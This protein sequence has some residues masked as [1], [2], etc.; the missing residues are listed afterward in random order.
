MAILGLTYKV[1]GRSRAILPKYRHS[2]HIRQNWN[3]DWEYIPY[4]T[5]LSAT[6]AILP[7]RSRAEFVYRFGDMKREDTESFFTWQSLAQRIAGGVYDAYIAIRAWAQDEPAYTLWTGIVPAQSFD[8]FATQT[9]LSPQLAGMSGDQRLVAYG[10]DHVVE[11]RSVPG[12]WVYG[13]GTGDH[14]D[15]APQ[16]NERLVRGATQIGNRSEFKIDYTPPAGSPGEVSFGFGNDVDSD[17]NPFAWSVRDVIEYLLF[18]SGQRP[19]VD[20]AASTEPNFVIGGPTT[21]LGKS[22]HDVIGYLDGLQAITRQEGRNVWSMLKE[23]LPRTRGIGATFVPKSDSVPTIGSG[24]TFF[25]NPDHL[26]PEGDMELQLFSL[27]D[28]PGVVGDFEFPQNP[29]SEVI[30]LDK[31]RDVEKAIISIDSLKT[32]DKVIVQ[33]SRTV[34]AFSCRTTPGEELAAEI[35]PAWSPADETAYEQ[36]RDI[37][38]GKTADEQR[39]DTRWERVFQTFR[40]PDDFDW[41]NG[42]FQLNPTYDADGEVQLSR[43]GAFLNPPDLLSWLPIQSDGETTAE[44]KE[45]RLLAPIVIVEKFD[46]EGD[47]TG[48]WQQVETPEDAGEPSGAS[49]T[50]E[51]RDG[52]MKISYQD[53]PHVLARNHFTP[54]TDPKFEPVFDYNNMIVTIAVRTDTRPTVEVLTGAPGGK[55]LRV[56]TI[57]I[58][59]VEV[60]VVAPGTVDGIRPH[61]QPRFFPG[62]RVVRD[63]TARLRSVAALAKAVYSKRRASVRVTR[64]GL[65]DIHPLGRMIAGVTVGQQ[66]TPVNAVVMQR[67]WD[68]VAE[69]TTVQTGILNLDVRGVR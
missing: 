5:A 16:F 49:V 8:I 24:P 58:P 20:H 30:V 22:T 41:T 66:S 44:S 21:A 51:D 47:P 7:G 39:T 35:E 61:G 26:L 2:V 46:D 65:L 53:V 4:L 68:F 38:D 52:L 62:G 57:P 11:R 10:W 56:L 37:V 23:L 48:V 9:V 12:A 19:L 27:T 1:P 29:T 40:F 50:I 15:W 69:T 3:D 14:I 36:L 33:G 59:E 32:Y 55:E 28:I 64:K 6:Q 63:D 67:T 17:G 42:V 43:G 31:D 60:W 45:P 54:V 13:D 25:V 34:S 18:W